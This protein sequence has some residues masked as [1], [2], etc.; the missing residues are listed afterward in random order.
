MIPENKSYLGKLVRFAD[1]KTFADSMEPYSSFF[2]L[3]AIPSAMGLVVREYR[4]NDGK[5]IFCEV[6]WC[7]KR[8]RAL[9]KNSWQG[10]ISSQELTD[11]MKGFEP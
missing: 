8:H 6:Q 4:P 7:S 3:L 11:D 2:F 1:P 5:V 10:L 9:F